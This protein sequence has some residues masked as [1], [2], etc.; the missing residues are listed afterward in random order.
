MRAPTPQP[1]LCKVTSTSRAHKI[2]PADPWLSVILSSPSLPLRPVLPLAPSLVCCPVTSEHD[3]P[4]RL[5]V[6]L[7]DFPCLHRQP[8]YRPAQIRALPRWRP[9]LREGRTAPYPGAVSGPSTPPILALGEYVR[10]L[11]SWVSQ[12]SCGP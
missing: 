8:G 11:G 9:G 1:P 7:P 2:R 4:S 12:L 5:Q 3:A 6:F 10:A